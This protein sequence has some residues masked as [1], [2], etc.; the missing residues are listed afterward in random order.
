MTSTFNI[1]NVRRNFLLRLSF[2]V[3]SRYISHQHQ[4]HTSLLLLLLLLRSRYF[5]LFQCFSLP[6]TCHE[7]ESFDSAVRE[8][9]GVE[10]DAQQKFHSG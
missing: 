7:I 1:D 6:T 10:I 8:I 9:K 5:P 3:N 4:D 2:K